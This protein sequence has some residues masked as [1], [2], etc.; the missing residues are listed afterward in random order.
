[1]KAVSDSLR[2]T[3]IRVLASSAISDPVECYRAHEERNHVEEAFN[4]LKSRLRC[5]RNRVH[6][7]ECLGGKLLVE[8]IAIAL[9]GMLRSRISDCGKLKGKTCT[10]HL[11][12][13]GRLLD[14]LNNI[15]M[16][17]FK[18]GWYFDEIAGKRRELFNVP[19]PDK[20]QKAAMAEE[21]VPE[22]EASM[23]EAGDINGVMDL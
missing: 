13:D 7:P 20:L 21:T 15:M 3:G 14:K 11:D 18:D 5:T 17:S 1:M 10:V 2:L 4:T 6:D 22:D 16:T 12:S 9:A 19:V 8:M 23:E